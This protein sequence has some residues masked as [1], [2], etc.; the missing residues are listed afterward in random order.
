[1]GGDAALKA[2]SKRMK[3]N[4]LG[5]LRY[6]CQM[7]EKQ[8]RDENGFKCH[9]Q[10]PAHQERLVLFASQPELFVGRFSEHFLAGFLA[11]LQQR[12]GSSAV[13][14]NTVYQEY[15]KDKQ[16]IHMN[17]TRWTTLTEFVKDL[18]RKGVV[19]VEDRDGKLWLT[20]VDRDTMERKQRAQEMERVRLNEEEAAEQS[21][22]RQMQTVDDESQTKEP[23]VPAGSIGT[24]E[25]SF[26]GLAGRSERQAKSK[27]NAFKSLA[28]SRVAADGNGTEKSRNRRKDRKQKSSAL[29]EIM[30]EGRE[31]AAAKSGDPVRTTPVDSTQAPGSFQADVTESSWLVE[32]I[33]VKCTGESLKGRSFYGK[34]GVVE[35]LLAPGRATVRFLHGDCVREVRQGDL[36]TV[37]P[38]P[39]GAVFLLRGNHKGKVGTLESIDEASYAATVRLENQE[40]LRSVDYEDFSKF[41]RPSH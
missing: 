18:G 38:K 34:K 40:V 32:G 1:M 35:S 25:L 13:E 21:L 8:C 17:S 6:Y 2:I 33:V 11:V 12:Y 9:T 15:I 24:I 31:K 14:A 16:H 30:A 7:C 39:G 41:Q 29:D 27:G 4:G 5:R 28:S 22:E 26:K 3:A 23:V 20:F 10:T 36:Q 37:I 19:R